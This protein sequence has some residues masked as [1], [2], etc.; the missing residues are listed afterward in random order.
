[1]A[2]A[3]GRGSIV[4]NRNDRVNEDIKFQAELYADYLNFER[5]LSPLTISAYGRELERFIVFAT[6][7]GRRDPAAVGGDD[8]RDYTFPSSNLPVSF[9]KSISWQQGSGSA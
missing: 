1:M 6:E 8:V 7:R 2:R 5:G 4:K 3:L 9:N